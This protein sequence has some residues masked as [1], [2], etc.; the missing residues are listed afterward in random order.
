MPIL[1]KTPLRLSLFSGGSDMKSFYSKETGAALSVTIDKFIYVMTHRTLFP[2]LKN[3]FPHTTEEVESLEEMRHA[4][5][6]ETLRLYYIDNNVTVA[7]ISDVPSLGSGLGSSSA[8]T[9]GLLNNLDFA[10]R[11]SE[12]DCDFYWREYLAKRACD[13]E[14]NK[15]GYPIGNQD[16]WA[17][18]LG[19]FNLFKFH[20]NEEVSVEMLYISEGTLLTFQNNLM[21]FY[22]GRGRSANAI[23]AKQQEAV[24][25]K[26]KFQLIQRNRDRALLATEVLKE[27]RVDEIGSMFWEAWFDKKQIVDGISDDF[28]DDL[29]ETCIR[30][31]AIGAKV[32]GAGGGGFMIVYAHPE[33]QGRITQA[34]TNRH[35]QCQ[36][37]P[38]RFC[39]SGTQILANSP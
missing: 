22:T 34:I 18:A 28:L 7:S 1:S 10:T 32:L 19:G 39:F 38:F 20:S 36:H 31:G 24:K 15:C 9:V 3:L 23:L 4:I 35:P 5:T 25:D 12:R 33:N 6:R 37:F 14:I 17:A 11:M 29:H 26:K 8:F 21:L 2:G 16:Q 30:N 13:I 27:G